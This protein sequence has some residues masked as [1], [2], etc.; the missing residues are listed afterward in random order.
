MYR[1]KKMALFSLSISG[2]DFFVCFKSSFF[3]CSIVSSITDET[4]IHSIFSPSLSRFVCLSKK[5]SLSP[6]VVKAFSCLFFMWAAAAAATLFVQFLLYAE[7]HAINKKSS[8]I[9]Q[10]CP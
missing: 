9:E 6:A 8:R 7:V 2:V 5:K 3:C 10:A 4:G 1:E